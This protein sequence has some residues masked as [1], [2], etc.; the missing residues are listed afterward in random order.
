MFKKF[1]ED[2]SIS[3]CSQVKSSV[4]RGIRGKLVDQMPILDDILGDLL[5]KKTP[6]YLVKWYAPMGARVHLAL[7]RRHP[8]VPRVPRARHCHGACGRLTRARCTCPLPRSKDHIQILAANEAF[9]FFQHYDGPWYPTLRLLHQ[10]PDL[11]PKLQ[12]DR[13]AIRFVLS[14]ANIM[15]PGLTSPGAKMEDCPVDCPVVRGAVWRVPGE[16]ILQAAMH[17]QHS[18]APPLAGGVLWDAIHP[19]TSAHV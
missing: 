9:L 18:S 8:S 6:V 3:S 14:G 7:A 1:S 19:C 2:D 13:G 16:A 11:L 17:V 10:Y 15:C 5:P 12:V 4:I